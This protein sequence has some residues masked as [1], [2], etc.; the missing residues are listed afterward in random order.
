MRK[1]V[2]GRMIKCA[3]ISDIDDMMALCKAVTKDMQVQGIDQWDEQYP[4]GEISCSDIDWGTLYAYWQNSELLG[5]VVLNQDQEPEYQTASWTIQTAETGMIHRLMVHPNMQGR[6]IASELL[7]FAEKLAAGRA[8][9]AIRLDVFSQNAN[10][11]RFYENRGYQNAE[12]VSFRKGEFICMEKR[13]K[14]VG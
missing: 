2:I 14:E 10:A 13:I 5:V 6:G 11:I 7:G 8:M 4:T 3:E 9:T 12:L 1:G